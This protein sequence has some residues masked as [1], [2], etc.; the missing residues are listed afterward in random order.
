M[1][2]RWMFALVFFLSI[3]ALAHNTS[4]VAGATLAVSYGGAP[5]AI[6]VTPFPNEDCVVSVQ[7]TEILPNGAMI[8]NASD[9]IYGRT[10]PQLNIVNTS[11][12]P[13][14]AV[15]FSVS[16]ASHVGGT[17]YVGVHLTWAATG[18]NTSG[19]SES[20][21]DG[22]GDFE[23]TVQITD[24]DAACG[25]ATNSVLFTTAPSA[26]ALCSAGTPGSVSP[27]TTVPWTWT[28][29]SSYGGSNASCASRSPTA[30]GACG[31]ANGAVLTATPSP[32]DLCAD[33]SPS[34]VLPGTATTP[35]TWVCQSQSSSGKDAAC[36]SALNG[37]CGTAVGSSVWN[38][39]DVSNFCSVGTANSVSAGWGDT[40]WTWTCNG[41]NGGSNAYCSG[42]PVG[43]NGACGSA[44]GTVLTSAPAQSAYCSAGT[45]ST[46]S[47]GSATV[48]WT[49]TCLGSNGGSN[50]SC[51]SAV[52]TASN[53]ACGAADGS[54]VKAAP[55]ANLCSAGAASAVAGTG[56]WGWTCAGS[57]G[58]NPA[59]CMAWPEPPGAVDGKC[60]AA[61][62]SVVAA[63]PAANLCSA[64]TASNVVGTGPWSW[65]CA[66]SNG[67]NNASCKAWLKGV[68]GV[69]G[70][71]N[72]AFLF[73]APAGPGLCTTGN[74][75]PV[76]GIGPWTWTCQG[77]GGV[78]SANANCT[79]FLAPQPVNGRCSVPFGAYL[80]KPPG[81]LCA[82]GAAGAV[83]GVGPWSWT[84]F[85]LNGG[86]N[87][88]C[89]VN[90]FPSAVCGSANGTVATS[91]PGVNLC[92]V[93]TASSI[94]GS[95][96]WTW[97]C[98]VG[99]AGV[100]ASC[101]T[102]TQNTHTDC[103][104][105]WGED[106]YPNLFATARPRSW[107]LGPYYVRYYWQTGAYLG[108]SSTDKHLY[109]LGPASSDKLLDLGLA[110]TWYTTAGCQ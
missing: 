23:F 43:V 78:G 84:C 27:S 38:P 72:G 58:G 28:C 100:S 110:S 64:G 87:A 76:A 86:V 20:D 2:A 48:A 17:A 35:W 106:H 61:D 62:G 55:S 104:F 47:T 18:Y 68:N 4:P 6:S 26:S 39:P 65:A 16:P 42:P 50:A 99:S 31:A 29:V 63:A 22:S 24:N 19:A 95:G 56:P 90:P 77:N 97:T 88:F 94:A 85:G 46:V 69:C 14:L 96:P 40:A 71:D 101:S 30:D 33:G 92:T 107:V 93:G 49:W 12:N 83:T 105:D 80:S 10:P 44:A 108:T 74:A 91:A 11:A 54:Y 73:V 67:G 32:A 3:P 60:G 103:L 81:T 41:I 5:G 15:Y 52:T 7:A 37:A 36:A 34:S 109:Y 51:A 45:V 53:G 98:S 25:S 1:L 66:G 21:C 13:A 8:G 89:Q 9:S 75:T 70:A 82:T 79:A 57:N 102:A 59:S